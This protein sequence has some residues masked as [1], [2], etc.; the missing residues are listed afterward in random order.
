MILDKIRLKCWLVEFMLLA[1]IGSAAGLYLENDWLLN[2]NLL[3]FATG[4]LWLVKVC[5]Y[6]YWERKMTQDNAMSIDCD[7]DSDFSAASFRKIG[8][9]EEREDIINMLENLI[10]S[11]Q[12][13]PW[14]Q[15][16]KLA[17]DKIKRRGMG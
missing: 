11:C 13:E 5:I 17:L 10:D 6:D 12:I 2:A 14:N 15:T 1:I 7:D 9:Y 16:A 4:V 3:L 8:A